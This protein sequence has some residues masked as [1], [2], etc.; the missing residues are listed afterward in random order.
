MYQKFLID[1]LFDHKIF[2]YDDEIRV[3][4]AQTLSLLL[5]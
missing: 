5:P 2:H 3:L 4:S 1:H